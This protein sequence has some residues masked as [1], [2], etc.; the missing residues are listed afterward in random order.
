MWSG[1][2]SD[3]GEIKKRLRVVG[4]ASDSVDCL[5]STILLL[6]LLLLSSFSSA[7]LDWMHYRVYVVLSFRRGTRS[8]QWNK[9]TASRE[10][11]VA[12]LM[13]PLDVGCPCHWTACMQSLCTPAGLE[14]WKTRSTDFIFVQRQM[15][16]KYDSVLR[17]P[18]LIHLLLLLLLALNHQPRHHIFHRP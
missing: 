17:R 12:A 3:R 14:L 8:N 9:K 10:W 13:M 2:E 18:L 15:T 5:H 6:L 4:R 1:V 16:N 7:A 11:I